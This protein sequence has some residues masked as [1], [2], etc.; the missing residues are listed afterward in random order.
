MTFYPEVPES[1]KATEMLLA[2][3]D[4][5]YFGNK[6]YVHT[7]LVNILRYVRLNIKNE[8]NFFM[9]SQKVLNKWR[10]FY[11]QGVGYIRR[12]KYGLRSRRMD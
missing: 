3:A 9:S 4:R 1:S 12:T 8:N 7:I 5:R 11:E 2:P 6:I 10:S